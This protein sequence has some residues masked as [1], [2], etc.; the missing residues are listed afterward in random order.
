MERRLGA[1]VDDLNLQFKSIDQRPDHPAAGEVVY[2]I[3]DVF[4][5]RNG[6]WEP[7][8]EFGAMDVIDAWAREAYLRAEFDDAGADHHL[9]AAVLGLDGQLMRNVSVKYWSDGFDKLGD[10]AYAGYAYQNTKPQSG[11]ANNVIS[12]G[13][14]YYPWD[15][16]VGPWCWTLADGAAEVVCGGGLPANNHVST[17]VV[18]QAVPVSQ[19]DGTVNFAHKI[20]LPTIMGG[21]AD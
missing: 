21:A 20:F 8:S 15:G 6:S 4:T 9:F 18:W 13:S 16:Q 12:S 3:K 19:D 1:W 11:W 7:S 14:N 2:R 5:T 10:P 17:F